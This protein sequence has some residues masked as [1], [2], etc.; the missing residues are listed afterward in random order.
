MFKTGEELRR[1]RMQELSQGNMERAQ[2]GARTQREAGNLGIGSQLGTLLV[3]AFMDK[4]GLGAGDVEKELIE[5]GA[6]PKTAEG[7]IQIQ[8]G[9]YDAGFNQKAAELDT[10]IKRRLEIEKSFAEK[11]GK[12]KGKGGSRPP[13]VTEADRMYV[14]GSVIS[15]AGNPEYED[16]K[17]VNTLAPMYTEDATPYQKAQGKT[18]NA[19]IAEQA[20]IVAHK[21]QE[22][23][24][25]GVSRE[26]IVDKM[27]QMMEMSPDIINP[28]TGFL[29]WRQ[30]GFIDTPRLNKAL[31]GFGTK[32]LQAADRASEARKAPKGGR[33]EG[34]PRVPGPAVTRTGEDTPAAEVGAPVPEDEDI[35]EEPLGTGPVPDQSALL[36]AKETIEK[37]LGSAGNK[38]VD[39][40]NRQ[41]KTAE[42]SGKPTEGLIRVRDNLLESSVMTKEEKALRES[43]EM[44]N[45]RLGIK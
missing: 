33:K 5:K 27:L 23:G 22:K 18:I 1:E 20:N 29:F 34:A 12:S 14:A 7:L 36:K 28:E 30:D 45:R 32:I 17:I 24:V 37:K 26:V 15:L 9:M 25:G 10:V 38:T 40:L 8:Q 2:Q 35:F 11:G 3:G 13:E 19:S 4:E 39:A 44:I 43:L 16:S 21:L 31:A 42:E 41:I 6:D